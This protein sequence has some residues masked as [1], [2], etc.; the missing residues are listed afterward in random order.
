MS[1]QPTYTFERLFDAPRELVWKAWT[2]PSLLK[3]WYGP[4]IETVIH[5]FDLRPGGAW[6]NE[7]K[8]GGNSDFSKMVFQ[9]VIAPEK[10]VWHHSS[11]DAN[12]KSASNMMMPDWPRL[13][14][15]TV[16]FTDAGDKTKVSLTQE[17]IDASEKELACFADKMSG[18]DNGW[19]S[20]YKLIDD[21]LEKLLAEQSS[22]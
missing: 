10:L 18:M 21:L 8:W 17:P 15:T 12:W 13:L 11:T 1:D 22:S 20:G 6:L 5:E 4:G 2:D 19:G 3:H 14:L 16:E 7:M 9:E